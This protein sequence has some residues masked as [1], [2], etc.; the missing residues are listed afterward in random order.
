MSNQYQMEFVKDI[1]FFNLILNLCCAL[2]KNQ[3]LATKKRKK[4]CWWK[5]IIFIEKTKQEAQWP[6]TQLK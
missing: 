1:Y 2:D 6:G 4:M 3:H 5:E